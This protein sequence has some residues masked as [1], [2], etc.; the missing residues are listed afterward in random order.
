MEKNV[1]PEDRVVRVVAGIAL[2]VLMYF[3]EMSDIGR[4]LV[5]ISAAVLILTGLLGRCLIYKL[6]DIDTSIQEQSYSTTDDRSG[7]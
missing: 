2:L 4:I 7:L 6:L 5:G 3:V 1:G